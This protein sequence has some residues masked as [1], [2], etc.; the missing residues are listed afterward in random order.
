ML[1]L[2]AEVKLRVVVIFPLPPFVVVF[3]VVSESRRGEL[4]EPDSLSIC[5][6]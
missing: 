5:V 1:V 6:V 3:V 4:V 2:A